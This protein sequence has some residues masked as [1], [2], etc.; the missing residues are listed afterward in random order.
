[1]NEEN[2]KNEK[3]YI[4]ILLRGLIERRGNIREAG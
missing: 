3:K 4:R 2:E 1:M